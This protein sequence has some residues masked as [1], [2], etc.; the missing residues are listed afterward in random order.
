MCANV[1]FLSTHRPNHLALPHHRATWRRRDGCRLQGRG[2]TAAPQCGTEVP[3]GECGGRPTSI[4]PLPARSAG[5]IGAEPP[6]HMHV[7][8]MVPAVYHALNA[9]R[10]EQG[11]PQSGWVFP[12][13]S[14]SG[15]LDRD[16][17]KAYHSRALESIEVDTKKQGKQ[18]PVK[19][20]PPYT[21]RHTA[22]TRL[23]EAG[24]DAFTLARIAGHSSITITQRYCHP[25]ADSIERAFAKLTAE[26]RGALPAAV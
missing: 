9:R 1:G 25:Q 14:K 7:L 12:A 16:T 19:A 3:A 5:C 4:S 23:A 6:Q 22:L 17:A 15:H 8:P 10:N 13:E 26:K 24:C 2:H 11:N 20:F 18:T 21:M